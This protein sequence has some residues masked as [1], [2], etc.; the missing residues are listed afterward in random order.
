MSGLIIEVLPGAGHALVVGGGTVAARKVRNLAASQFTVTVVA[1]TVV[2]EI[3]LA[4]HVTVFEREYRKGD[5]DL[6]VGF[7]LVFA[8]TDSREVNRAIGVAARARGIPVLVADRQ[9]E[10]TFFTPA[11]LRDGDLAVAVSTGGASP[12]LAR[13]IRERIVAALGPGWSGVLRTARAERE[14]HLARVVKPERQ[15][16]GEPPAETEND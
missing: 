2:E 7:A 5:L 15:R 8:C 3:R 1:P 12:T 6:G 14:Q 9:A 10:S 16:T 11:V 4:P 13:V